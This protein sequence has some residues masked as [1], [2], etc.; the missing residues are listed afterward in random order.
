M[1]SIVLREFRSEGSRR[2]DGF[3]SAAPRRQPFAGRHCQATRE[4][5]GRARRNLAVAYWR[6]GRAVGLDPTR[7]SGR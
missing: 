5:C 3:V 7:S 6:F 1:Q 4:R 2:P